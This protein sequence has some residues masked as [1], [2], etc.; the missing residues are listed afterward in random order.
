ME[1]GTFRKNAGLIYQWGRKDPFPAAISYTVQNED[2]SYQV[3]GEPT[4]YDIS[5][6]ELPKVSSKA[7]YEGSIA[8]GIAH[9]DVFYKVG[10]RNTGN[11]DEYGEPI[12]EKVPRT[13]DWSDTSDDDAYKAPLGT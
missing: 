5:N 2:Y 8:L 6:N 12:Y 9:P 4:L 1:K 7:S 11:V 10:S 13:A 3:D